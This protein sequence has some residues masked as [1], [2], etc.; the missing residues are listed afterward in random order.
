MRKLAFVFLLVLTLAFG[1]VAFAQ[2]AEFCGNLSAEDCALYNNSAMQMINA[3]S[4]NGNLNVS[5]TGIPDSEDVNIT[6]GASG[7]Y[8]LDS[9]TTLD[10]STI[11]P[12]DPMAA[13]SALPALLRAFDGSL[14]LDLGLPADAASAGLPTNLTLDLRLVEG[15]GYINFDTISDLIGPMTAQSGMTLAGWGGLDLAGLIEQLGPALAQFA[16]PAVLGQMGGVD[17]SGLDMNTINALTEA[18]QNVDINSYLS[19][20]RV[21][22]TNGLPTFTFSVDL[23]GLG[24]DQAFLD[25]VNQVIDA[26]AAT[27]ESQGTSPEDL[28]QIRDALPALIQAADF[29]L[30]TVVDPA[31]GFAVGYDVSISWN[32]AAASEQLIAAGIIGADEAIAVNFSLDGS[33]D[34]AD[35]NTATVSAPEGAQILPLEQ[36]GTMLGGGQ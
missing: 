13:I 15:I 28:Q 3:A 12:N 19:L 26:Q 9:G 20:E 29:S 7:A 21:E 32:G 27:L 2:D 8:S 25:V 4:F 31:T 24:N 35:I 36:L 5:I 16:D 33:L 30:T 6:L 11:D 10:L 18:A 22:D 14:T 1:S 17:T 23:A 34:F